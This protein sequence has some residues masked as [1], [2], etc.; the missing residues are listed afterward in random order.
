VKDPI[1]RVSNLCIHLQTGEERNSF[2]INKEDHMIPMIA[3]TTPDQEQLAQ[4]ATEQI[5]GDAWTQGQEP[6]L[7]QRIAKEL[8][9]SVS[10]IAD[11]EL[12]LYDTQPAAIGGVNKDFLY[13]ARLDNLA[14]V[15]CAIEALVGHSADTSQ[16]ESIAMVVCFDHEEVGSVSSHGAGSPV[17]AEAIRR[18]STALL[19]ADAPDAYANMI[20]KSFCL[21]IDQAHAV[22]P[23]Y[24][25]RHDSQHAP[26]MNKGIVIKTNVN[27]RYATNGLTGFILRELGRK[28]GV[29][30][31]EFVGTCCFFVFVVWLFLLVGFLQ[32][33][34]SSGLIQSCRDSI[35]YDISF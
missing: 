9:V 16:D 11:F 4:S 27:Q 33:F 19:G 23:N 17:M 14:T 12:S 13:S 1:A 2:V 30:M 18:V 28:V 22:H 35:L 8:G 25:S 32:I 29:P 15:F 21:S 5:N 7:L 3:T 10:Q 26:L 31:Q 24:A 6:L 20:A 34:M